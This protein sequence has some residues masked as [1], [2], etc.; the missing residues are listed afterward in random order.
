[1]VAATAGIN[2]ALK[3]CAR[4]V[5]SNAPATAQNSDSIAIAVTIAALTAPRSCKTRKFCCLACREKFTAL[6]TIKVP[7]TKDK[8]P[9]A[10]KLVC[11]LPVN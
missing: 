1:M 8:S 10:V 5:P 6:N 3:G 7:T 11:K 9:S 4:S 2:A